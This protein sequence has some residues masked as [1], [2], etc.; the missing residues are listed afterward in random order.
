LPVWSSSGATASCQASRTPTE[1]EQRGHTQRKE[2]AE[3]RRE[4]DPACVLEEQARAGR[5]PGSGECDRRRRGDP[6]RD[7][8]EGQ[9]E[10]EAAGDPR[11][12]ECEPRAALSGR[13]SEPVMTKRM[14]IVSAAT[15]ASASGR[16]DPRLCCRST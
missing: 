10:R 9:Q 11:G 8:Y 3:R 1:V 5:L 7:R 6:D 16:C 15:I 2:E 14:T 13:I 12:K 4:P